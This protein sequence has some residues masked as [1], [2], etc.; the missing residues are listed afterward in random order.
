VSD[1]AGASGARG[2]V[3]GDGALTAA[4]PGCPRFRWPLFRSRFLFPPTAASVVA[5]CFFIILSPV[6]FVSSLQVQTLSWVQ[7]RW[8]G[9]RTAVTGEKGDGSFAFFL[10]VSCSLFHLA[11][12]MQPGK[13]NQ[14]HRYWVTGRCI[15][16]M[17]C[18]LFFGAT[19]LPEPR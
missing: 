6:P 17:F 15:S 8:A 2:F 5:G 19:G 12:V 3:C 14:E 16:T 4:L 1:V 13:K 11:V 10:L 7:A 9:R 18:L